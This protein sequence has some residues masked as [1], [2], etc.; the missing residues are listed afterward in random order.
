MAKKNSPRITALLRE[1]EDVLERELALATGFDHPADFKSALLKSLGEHEGF[2]E[3]LRETHAVL[4][5]QVR[6]AQPLPKGPPRGSRTGGRH[7]AARHEGGQPK[8]RKKA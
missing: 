6:P 4:R 2:H 7:A 3:A 8:G 1:M 5:G